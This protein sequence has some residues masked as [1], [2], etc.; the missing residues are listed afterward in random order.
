MTENLRYREISEAPISVTSSDIARYQDVH[1][2]FVR[3]IW[4]A[5]LQDV[6]FDPEL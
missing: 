5:G 6:W 1:E 4:D 3:R 2:K